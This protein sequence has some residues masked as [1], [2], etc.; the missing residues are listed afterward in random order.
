MALAEF[1]LLCADIEFK[2]RSAAAPDTAENLEMGRL[3]AL[4][5]QGVTR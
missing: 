4:C 3:Y 1:G 5:F 2:P